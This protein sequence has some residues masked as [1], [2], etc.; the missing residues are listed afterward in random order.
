LNRRVLTNT[1][2]EANK[3]EKQFL[4]RWQQQLVRNSVTAFVLSI[5]D[6]SAVVAASVFRLPFCY[7]SL[8]PSRNSTHPVRPELPKRRLFA[9]A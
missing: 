2:E 6:V 7:A 3:I 4:K 5:E 1:K 8:N 9:Y